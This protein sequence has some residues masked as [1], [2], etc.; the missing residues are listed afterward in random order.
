MTTFLLPVE[1]LTVAEPWRLG[2]V[3][4]HT[5]GSLA[6]R[7]S[8]DAASRVLGAPDPTSA[9]DLAREVFTSEACIAEVEAPNVDA[10]LDALT[11][12]TDLLRVFQH[13][14]YTISRTTAFGLP[15]QVYR[16]TVRYLRVGPQAAEG[17]RHR[18]EILGWTFT[19]DAIRAWRD[20]PVYP[21][22]ADACAT[23]DVDPGPRRALLGVQL[24]SQAILEHRPPF[25]LLALAMAL[26]TMLLDQA[27]SGQALRLARRAAFLTCGRP[28]GS[29]CGRDRD[30]CCCLT[31]DPAED[32]DRR[33]LQRVRKLADVDTRWRCSEWLRYQHWHDLRSAV[34]HGDLKTADEEQIA[35]AEYGVLRWLTE[36][37]LQWFLDH[38]VDPLADLDRELQALPPVPSWQDNIPDPATYNPSAFQ[39]PQT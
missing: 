32:S 33:A 7:L 24:L 28:G 21:L 37:L 9:H 34:V 25:K 39:I 4:L 29:L 18:G 23:E 16:S 15:G 30:S 17:F 38:P 5:E 27:P 2:P 19:A 1:G 36:P 20:S 3:T 13:V 12:V 10:A 22:L 26:E 14:R 31:L 8:E 11:T 35:E 6:D